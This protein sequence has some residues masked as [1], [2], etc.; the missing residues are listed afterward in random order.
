[1]HLLVFQPFPIVGIV[2]SFLSFV[3][4]EMLILLQVISLLKDDTL[5]IRELFA[6]MRSSDVSMESK[7]E[8]VRQ[9]SFSF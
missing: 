6:K 7:R 2:T 9:Y 4:Y 1:M 5:F 8:L 3:T